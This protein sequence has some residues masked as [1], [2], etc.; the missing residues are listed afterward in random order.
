MSLIEPEFVI[1]SIFLPAPTCIFVRCILPGNGG[2]Y[3]TLWSNK[4]IWYIYSEKFQTP[5]RD[6]PMVDVKHNSWK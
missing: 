1:W 6:F 3:S 2:L 4:L 5:S